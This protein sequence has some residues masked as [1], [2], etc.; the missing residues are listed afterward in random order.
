MIDYIKATIIGVSYADLQSNQFLNCNG[1]YFINTEEVG[2]YLYGSYKGLNFKLY[3]PTEANPEGRI[4]M[5]GSLHKF[6]NDGKHNHNDFGVKQIQ[7]VLAELKEKFNIEPKNM[8]LRNLEIGVNFSPPDNP[9]KILQYA[10]FHK[11]EMLKWHTV[12]NQGRYKVA[13]YQNHFIKLYDKQWHS[14]KR[15]LNYFIETLRFE[16]KYRKMRA[17]NEM[18]IVSLEDLINYGLQNFKPILLKQWD[19]VLFYDYNVLD[20]TKYRQDYS[21]VN[22]WLELES[23]NF[24]Y[25]RNNLDSLMQEA[26]QNLKKSIRDV[27]SKK[28]DALCEQTDQI[29]PL[30]IPINRTVEV[31]A[32]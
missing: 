25:H 15:G 9:Q 26:P 28:C 32:A 31:E 19:S 7:E 27:I 16:I 10:L 12:E 20:A 23:S 8:I 13:S 21:N 22:Y 11:R 18:G 5:D 24:K 4:M 14:E 29:S 2:S 17:L 3:L 30:Y 6:Y 1:N